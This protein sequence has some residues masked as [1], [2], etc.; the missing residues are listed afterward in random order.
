VRFDPDEFARLE[1]L[2]SAARLSVSGYCRQAALGGKTRR[3]QRRILPD[4]ATLA[5]LVAQLGKIGANLN[6]LTKLANQRQ[7][8]PPSALDACLAE[9]RQAA[10]RI[11][12]AF[13]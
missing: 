4:A 3:T 10:Q 1:A 13:R 8:V 5:P 9:V 12:E 2:A 11:E 6:Q 7:I